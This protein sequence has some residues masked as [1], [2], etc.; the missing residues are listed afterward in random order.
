M[1]KVKVCGITNY[2]DAAMAVKLGAHALGFIFA[3]SPRWITPE[4]AR[5]I[6]HAVPP[7]VQTV[8]VFVNERPDTMRQI[9][10]FCGL[11]LVQLHG[12]EPPEVCCEFMPHA[13][14]AFRVRDGSVLQCI[15]PY[16]RKI[17][18]MLFDTY[19]GEGRGGTGKTFDWN[20]AARGKALGIPLI[21][22][23]GLTPS[24]IEKAISVVNPYAVDVNSGIEE[25]TGKK[26]HLLMEKLM[27]KIRNADNRGILN[28]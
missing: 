25:R 2:Q 16:H 19:T 3:Q 28:D 23:G 10:R 5:D 7:F 22:S 13:I 21:L 9:V 11:D 15:K 20:L 1:V 8:G 4:K 24:N 12:D 6:I 27:E 14:K 26:D 17:K 18:A